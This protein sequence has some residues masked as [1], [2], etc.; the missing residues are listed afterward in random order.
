M[1]RGFWRVH[2]LSPKLNCFKFLSRLKQTSTFKICAEFSWEVSPIEFNTAYL[3]Q[4]PFLSSDFFPDL[5]FLVL[6]KKNYTWIP[7]SIS[8]KDSYLL[9]HKYFQSS[10]KVVTK[11]GRDHEEYSIWK[12]YRY[13]WIWRENWKPKDF[14]ATT[15]KLTLLHCHVTYGI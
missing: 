10:F 14:N 13:P 6:P 8:P 9:C 7:I 3:A 1:W 12:A 11:W 2:P 4:L 15:P 5:I